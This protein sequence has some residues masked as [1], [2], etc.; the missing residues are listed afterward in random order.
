MTHNPVA[1]RPVLVTGG[2]GFIG[3]H[4]VRQ[5]VGA[6]AQVRV[7]DDMSSGRPENLGPALARVEL[8]EGDICDLAAVRRAAEGAAIIIHLAAMVSVVQS[9][10]EPLRAQAVNATGT[11]NVLE[12]ARAAGVRR[13]VQA[14]SCAVYGEP[15]RLPVDET[16]PPCPLSPYAATKLAAEQ[17]GQLY[18]R[19]YGLETVALR[20]FNVYGP[21]QD[22]TSPYAAAV[23][24][25]IAALRAGR[26]PTIYGDGRQTR[27]FVYV[28]DVVR[29]LWTAATAPGIAGEVF[30]VGR[31]ES[32]S[33]VALV[34]TLCD[35]LGV[36]CRPEFAPPRP[37]EVRHSR[38]DVARFAARAGF[39]ATTGLRE[40]LRETLSL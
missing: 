37:G 2:A 16:T 5:L 40:G 10:E 29:A 20:F 18:T 1:D 12:A 39:C 13:V 32:V 21:R 14:S 3:S 26:Q 36:P 28:G 35:L 23:P 27:D 38:A 11:L 34:E 30:N 7:L 4:V 24:R 6:G 31:G 8:I 15:E 33:V 9:V 19:L 17:A 25:F 22:P